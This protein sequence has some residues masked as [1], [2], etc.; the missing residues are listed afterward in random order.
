MIK[1]IAII[2]AIFLSVISCSNQKKVVDDSSGCG[3]NY[4]SDQYKV[5]KIYQPVSTIEIY[6]IINKSDTIYIQELVCTDSI[7]FTQSFKEIKVSEVCT[8]SYVQGSTYYGVDINNLGYFENF[9]ILRTV[10]SCFDRFD[11]QVELKLNQ[12]KIISTEY[13]N[14]KLIFYHKF[15]LR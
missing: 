4:D 7:K 3:G 11:C 10:N 1:R 5:D 14:C 15:I 12:M 9:E 2:C 13:F 8:E 6:S